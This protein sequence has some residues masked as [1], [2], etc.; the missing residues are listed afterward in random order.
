MDHSVFETA[1]MDR[2]PHQQI[3]RPGLGVLDE[4][5]EVAVFLQPTLLFI[6]DRLPRSH[7]LIP[8][9]TSTPMSIR[10]FGDVPESDFVQVAE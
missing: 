2:H 10:D 3:F 4:D 8:I 7:V 9:F 1:V 5:V 6:Y